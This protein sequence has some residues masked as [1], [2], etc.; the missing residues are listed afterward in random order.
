MNKL[1]YKNFKNKDFESILAKA[2]EKII[3]Y[4]KNRQLYV[5]CNGLSL[6]L[7]IDFKK[8]AFTNEISKEKES[9]KILRITTEKQAENFQWEF[10]KKDNGNIINGFIY[11]NKVYDLYNGLDVSDFAGKIRDHKWMD[12]YLFADGGILWNTGNIASLK[13]VTFK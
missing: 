5:K 2:Y 6:T 12:N 11:W 8:N 13:V 7:Q 10:G 9:G 4:T 1:T 3:G